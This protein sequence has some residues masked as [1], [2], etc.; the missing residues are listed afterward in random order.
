MVYGLKKTPTDC[1]LWYHC[2][3]IWLLCLGIHFWHH[4]CS[5]YFV[6]YNSKSLVICYWKTKPRWLHISRFYQQK[7]HLSTSF[8]DV[9]FSDF[10]LSTEFIPK[11]RLI[12][13]IEREGFQTRKIIIIKWL[14]LGNIITMAFKSTLL[15]SLIQIRYEGKMDSLNDVAN[16][17]LPILLPNNTAPRQMFV[18]D[19]RQV[20]RKM[21]NNTIDYP[22]NGTVPYQILDMCVP[23]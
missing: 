19:P 2:L 15:S 5:I 9:F 20:M 14:F 6:D 11:R 18:S 7:Y 17:G 3:S 16:S 23:C 21:S 8:E 4:Y 13:W 1:M 12:N 22:Y 10:F